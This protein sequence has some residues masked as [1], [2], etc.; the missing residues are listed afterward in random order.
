MGSSIGNFTRADAARFLRGFADELRDQD[1]VL[2]GLD[3]CQ[4]K[5]KISVAYNDPYGITHN[6]VRN[7]LVH[8]NRI[9]GKEAF[10]LD[11]WEVIGEYDVATCRHQAFYVPLKDISVN[12]VHFKAGE[13]VRVEESNKYSAAQSE[14]LWEAAGLTVKAVFGDRTGHYSELMH[15]SSLTVATFM[16]ACLI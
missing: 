8:A 11:E 10:R 13:R 2:V 12:N 4:D 7:G 6:F 15:F 3:G 14:Q 5:E 9:L 16:A 1:L